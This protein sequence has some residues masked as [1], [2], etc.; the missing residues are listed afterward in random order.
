MYVQYLDVEMSLELNKSSY[1]LAFRF[2]DGDLLVRRP[3]RTL[4]FSSRRVMSRIVDTADQSRGNTVS[5]ARV[6]D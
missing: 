3:A 1:V 5:G 6:V 2:A 4:K